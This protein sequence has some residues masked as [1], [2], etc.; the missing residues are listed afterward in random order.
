MVTIKIYF[1]KYTETNTGFVWIQ[2]YLDRKKVNFTT[3]IKCE[4]RNWNQKKSCVSASDP[5]H[6]DKNLIVEKYAARVNDVFVRYRL[7]N[8]KLTREAFFK[9]YNRPDD[10]DTFFAFARDY[11][12][13][14]SRMNELATMDVHRT[15]LK[16]VEEY[17]PELH[18]DDITKDWLDGYYA[19]LR[20]DLK[21][22]ENTAYKNMSTF[23]KYVNAA[24]NEGYMDEN[25]FKG[26]IIKRT[27]ANYTYLNEKELGELFKIYK[28]GDIEPKYYKVLEFFLF[29][30]LSS[31]HV[32]DAK[33]LK[34]EQ[35]ASDYFI[36][37]R[38]KNRNRKPEPVNVPISKSLRSLLTNIV[39]YRKKGIIFEKL[40]ADQTM[41]E[42]L[43]KIA[44]IAEI[45][46]NISH[47]TGRHTFA[48][49]FL[50]KTKDLT[51]LKE[52][53]GHSE[54]RETLIYAHVLDES[55]QE[56]IRCFDNFM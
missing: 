48:T 13:K 53:L 10:Y 47:K 5:N 8:K 19:H 25:P 42:Y 50:R 38:F 16:K 44:E 41:N 49:I 26:W 14:I 29:M 34:L 40:P 6:K 45:N 24:C 35:F 32:G 7:R 9:A 1:R 21:N 20:K 30:S 3:G 33:K 37:Y 22:N 15:V 46:K 12:K 28:K 43:K 23:R 39:G 31:L 18:F 55:K 4:E 52:I 2:F 17:A 36:Y 27:N 11:Q 54:L 56:G 51:S